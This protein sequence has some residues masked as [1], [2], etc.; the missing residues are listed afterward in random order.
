LL[1]AV[2]V[3]RKGA[4]KVRD[5]SEREERRDDRFPVSTNERRSL[6]LLLGLQEKTE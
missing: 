2:L 4:K 3:K 1:G 6:R 5:R